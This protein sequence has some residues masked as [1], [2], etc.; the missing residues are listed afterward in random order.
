MDDI[1][2]VNGVRYHAEKEKSEH[3]WVI[4]RSA[5]AGVFFGELD[6][7]NGNSVVLNSSRNFL[8]GQE[9]GM[10]EVAVNGARNPS[11]IKLRIAV[12]K[13]LIF[14]VKDIMHVTEKAQKS[15][16]EYPVWSE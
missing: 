16:Q 13:R 3:P 10:S 15:L 2:L 7:I 1:I 5:K 6:E 8:S 14:G 9:G 12:K 4:V 11:D